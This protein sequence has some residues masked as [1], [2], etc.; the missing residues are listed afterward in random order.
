MDLSARIAGQIHPLAR[1]P[2]ILMQKTRM[3]WGV[4]KNTAPVTAFAS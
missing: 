4:S 3:K 2:D 1:E